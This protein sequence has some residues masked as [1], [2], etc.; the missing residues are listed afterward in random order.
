MP[1]SG[2]MHSSTSQENVLVMEEFDSTESKSP[3]I[4][5]DS[6]TALDGV[7]TGQ[8]MGRWGMDGCCLQT[9]NM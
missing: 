4:T 1:S 7:A 9:Q 3:L 5:L 8:K 6:T 2:K